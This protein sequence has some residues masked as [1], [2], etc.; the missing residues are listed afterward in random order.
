VRG[1]PHTTHRTSLYIDSLSLPLARVCV[2]LV[3]CVLAAA[4]AAAAAAAVAPPPPV[5]LGRASLG[6]SRSLHSDISSESFHLPNPSASSLVDRGVVRS[7]AVVDAAD[8]A[9]TAVELVVAVLV[10]DARASRCI[11]C[12]VPRAPC[13]SPSHTHTHTRARATTQHTRRTAASDRGVTTAALSSSFELTER[14]DDV[15]M[16]RGDGVRMRIKAGAAVVVDRVPLLDSAASDVAGGVD[17]GVSM[18]GVV[19]F[20]GRGAADVG[21]LGAATAATDAG[22]ATMGDAALESSLRVLLD[23][24]GRSTHAR[25]HTVVTRA[26]RTHS[27]RTSRARHL[28]RD[29]LRERHAP[30]AR[31]SHSAGA[32]VAVV[33]DCQLLFQRSCALHLCECSH[34]RLRTTDSKRHLVQIVDI[35]CARPVRVIPRLVIAER[36]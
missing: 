13:E 2:P 8:D 24:A 33:I 20:N 31:L 12:D 18:T 23:L 5:R 26:H 3:C 10:V 21:R 15:S 28:W 35:A 25:A 1:K 27:T 29:A 14:H 22:G 30:A 17:V 34:H 19:L 4:A 11:D 16:P 36:L 7:V 6:S 32:R 9:T